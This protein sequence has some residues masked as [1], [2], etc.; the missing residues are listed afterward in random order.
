VW[1]DRNQNG[2]TDAGEVRSLADVGLTA[3]NLE[4]DA[5]ARQSAPGV[6]EAGRSSAS[7]SDGTSVLLG[8]AAFAFTSLTNVAASSASQGQIN[9]ASDT[10][11]NLLQLTLHDLLALPT[12]NLFDTTNT[13]L[14]S[15][16]PLQP[17][18]HQLMV[19]GDSNDVVQI[20]PTLLTDTHTVV[21]HNDHSYQVYTVDSAHT[22]LLIDQNI[23]NAGRVL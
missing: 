4:S 18:Q 7:A 13:T 16:T 3:I 22:Q 23:V 20:D 2:V 5:V 14:L 8:D 17:A 6:Y 10:S 19:T 9:L 12:E 1:Q 15:G 11:A 21:S